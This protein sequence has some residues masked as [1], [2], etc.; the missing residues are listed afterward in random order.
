MSAA[1]STRPLPAVADPTADRS[2]AELVAAACDH[3]P[4]AWEELVLRYRGLICSIA[5]SF[6]LGEPDVADVVQN[7]WLRALERLGTVREPEHLGGWLAT[8]A[9]RECLALLRRRAR[10]AADSLCVGEV[11]ATVPGPETVLLRREAHVIVRHAV[12]ELPGRRRALVGALF[13]DV[14]SSY[15]D[16]A[17]ALDLP[18]GSIGPTRRRALGV[19]RRTL[20]HAGL[21]AESVA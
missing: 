16:V 14:V 2:T 15:A 21:D 11:R 7:T 20:E 5:R 6:R 1:A 17:R 3:D 19:L 13:D 8:T 9:H 10:D 12:A 4:R 18:P